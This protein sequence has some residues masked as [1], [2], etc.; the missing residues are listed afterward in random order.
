[1]RVVDLDLPAKNGGKFRLWFPE[2][3]WKWMLW[4]LFLPNSKWHR[5]LTGEL[6]RAECLSEEAAAWMWPSRQVFP[7]GWP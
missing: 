3:S 4:L 5:V 6:C 7:P 1:M 2:G